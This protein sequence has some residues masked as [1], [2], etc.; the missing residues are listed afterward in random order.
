MYNTFQAGQDY[1]N[2]FPNQKKLNLF[3]PDY[4]LIRLVKFASKVMPAF[5]CFA[6][7][8]QYCFADPE[9][10]ITANATLTALFALS[11]PFQGLYWLGRRAKSP[12]PLSLLEWYETLR[13]KLISER[14]KIAD[15]AVP[16]Y[17]DFANLLQLAEKT[18]GQSYF[19]EL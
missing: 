19:D 8:W 18:W 2:T 15:Q 3:M 1:L 7:I 17:Q 13:Q 4:R 9:Q 14:H 6:I 10:S 16:S 11:I 5:A 12:L